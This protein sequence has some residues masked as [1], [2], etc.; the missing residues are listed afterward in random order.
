MIKGKEKLNSIDSINVREL[1]SLKQ[2][3]LLCK[4]YCFNI[5][6]FVLLF[7]LIGC[8]CSQ[9]IFKPKYTARTQIIVQPKSSFSNTGQTS[10]DPVTTYKD[11]ITSQKVLT[12]LSDEFYHQI[13]AGEL[14]HS[15]SIDNTQ[16][17]QLMTIN[18]S[19][20]S[21]KASYLVA[22]SLA[23]YIS[24]NSNQLVKNTSV[25]VVSHA[26]FPKHS[27]IYSPIFQFIV[28]AAIGLV[29][30][31]IIILVRAYLYPRVFYGQFIEDELKQPLLGSISFNKKIGVKK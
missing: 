23:N 30:S 19:L 4:K 27:T 22:N 13:S 5:I 25:K 3:F 12:F 8:L 2:Y 6:A 24:T 20:D 14:S 1:I 15:I 18:V 26:I 31:M 17:S 11:L 10:S 29:I 21:A 9:T 16:G 28:W 7:G